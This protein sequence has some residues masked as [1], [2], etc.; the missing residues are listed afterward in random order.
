M[1]TCQ[2]DYKSKRSARAVLAKI[3]HQVMQQQRSS[4]QQQARLHHQQRQQ[5]RHPFPRHAKRT[6]EAIP[7]LNKVYLSIPMNCSEH[8]NAALSKNGIVFLQLGALFLVLA[9][10]TSLGC[11][12]LVAHDATNNSCNQA[13]A[14][15]TSSNGQTD[16]QYE[17]CTTTN[18]ALSKN[19]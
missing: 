11:Q 15:G 14:Q 7:A 1:S 4:Q 13:N 17:G 3:P 16:C 2:S 8:K 12:P 18:L 9:L 19:F 6:N 10:F 5:F